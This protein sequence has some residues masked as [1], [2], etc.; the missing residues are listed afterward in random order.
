MNPK[1]DDRMRLAI[2]A[3]NLVSL[4]LGYNPFDYLTII[5]R[6]NQTLIESLVGKVKAV[7]I[8]AK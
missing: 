6:P 3:K 8:K 1:T 2:Y 7:G 4:T 5:C